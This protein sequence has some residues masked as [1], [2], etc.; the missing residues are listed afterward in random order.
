MIVVNGISYLILKRRTVIEVRHRLNSVICKI[1]LI[2]KKKVLY[3]SDK[4]E[5]SELEG[6]LKAYAFCAKVL[7]I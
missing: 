5:L 1:E 7:K 4:L 6:Q 2:K 3:E